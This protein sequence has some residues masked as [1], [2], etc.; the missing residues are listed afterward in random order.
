MRPPSELGIIGL[1][2][3]FV[4]LLLVIMGAVAG[5]GALTDWVLA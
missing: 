3:V 4:A 5:L 1:L 2:A